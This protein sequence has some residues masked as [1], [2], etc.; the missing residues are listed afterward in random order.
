MRQRP[1]AR[2]KATAHPLRV[3]PLNCRAVNDVAEAPRS[4]PFATA[5]KV[6]LVIVIIIATGRSIAQD[7]ETVELRSALAAEDPK[8]A[9]YLAALV[10]AD[11]S[12]GN[13]YDVLVNGDKVF[14]AML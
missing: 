4:R 7:Q 9:E 2:H 11:L 1:G 3:R 13:S 12:F 8:A 14:P 5:L 10:A 6:L